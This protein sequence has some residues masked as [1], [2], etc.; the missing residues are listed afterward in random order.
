MLKS[1]IKIY[2]YNG[3]HDLDIGL[4]GNISIN[5]RFTILNLYDVKWYTF[6]NIHITILEFYT[7]NLAIANLNIMHPNM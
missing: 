5:P 1:K 6:I 7:N 3:I 4:K 2:Y